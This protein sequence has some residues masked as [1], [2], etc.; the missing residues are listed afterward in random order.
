MFETHNKKRTI[1]GTSLRIMNSEFLD[2]H[3]QGCI[4]NQLWYSIEWYKDT[5]ETKQTKNNLDI[6]KSKIKSRKH[7][8]LQV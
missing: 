6:Y 5:H 4:A 7:S 1:S 3:N 8:K 2:L